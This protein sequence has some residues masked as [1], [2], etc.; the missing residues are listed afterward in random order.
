MSDMRRATASW[1]IQSCRD[2]PDISA[3]GSRLLVPFA[4]RRF[5]HPR[6]LWL[7]ERWFMAAGVD[8]RIP[9][10]QNEICACFLEKFAVSAPATDSALLPDGPEDVL[11]ADRYGGMG[12]RPHGGSGRCGSSGPFNAKGVGR[13]PLVSPGVDWAHS[14]GCMSIDEAIREVINSE[15]AAAELPYDTVPVL[16]VIDTGARFQTQDG[17]D[18]P[19]AV[20]VRP[21]FVRLAHFERSV[22]GTSGTKFSD[23]AVDAQRTADA[24]AAVVSDPEKLRVAN[25]RFDGMGAIFHRIAIQTGVC[26]AHRLWQ[27]RLATG[28]ITVN[29]GLVDFGSFR[30]VPSW[31][32]AVG[33]PGETFG[34]DMLALRTAIESVCFHFQKYGA[35]GPAVPD[36]KSLLRDVQ[37]MAQHAFEDACIAAIGHGTQAVTAAGLGPLFFEYFARQQR[38]KIYIGDH[39]TKWRRP[40][41][42]EALMAP[43][44]EGGRFTLQE[45]AICDA[46]R[47]IASRDPVEGGAM[48]ARARRWLRPRPL[49]YYEIAVPR[50]RRIANRLQGAPTDRDR[51][52]SYIN[53]CLSRCRRVWRN[54]PASY[55]VTAQVTDLVSSALDCVDRA[56]NEHR[57]WLEGHV[58]G[59]DFHFFG[60]KVRCSDVEGE[61]PRDQGRIFF[62]IGER[63]AHGVETEIGIGGAKLRIPAPVF[64]YS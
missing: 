36:A 29:G 39:K 3:L 1:L 56:T 54:L 46:L 61:M 35:S 18:S 25:I 14:H 9:D 26:R 19:R 5:E 31:R 15:I 58:V 16:A 62:S 55:E 37:R 24:V 30:A 49:L 53:G 12:S 34:D 59:S 44:V 20:V 48:L 8:V 45:R 23:Q 27:G 7:N 2:I 51:V 17:A 11:W 13:T 50:S 22:F 10:I 60:Q 47:Q 64:R 52:T 21:N 32:A 42:F 43:A 33:G 57:L 38:E 40:W 6:I 41:L 28:N 4:V 63:Q